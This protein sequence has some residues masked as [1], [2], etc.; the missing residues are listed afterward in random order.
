MTS[1]AERHAP[2]CTVSHYVL[3]KLSI[4]IGNCDL[5]IEKTEQGTEYAKRLGVIR[6][7]ALTTVNELTEHQRQLKAATPKT[8]ERRK[9]G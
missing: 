1:K 3:N 8:N 6:E 9:A 7:V 2:A 4:I 5:L